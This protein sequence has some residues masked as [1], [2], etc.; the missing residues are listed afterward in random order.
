MA[1]TLNVPIRFVYVFYFKWFCLIFY[2]FV[3]G[4]FFFLGGGVVCDFKWGK[5]ER[6]IVDLFVFN[7]LFSFV[8]FLFLE[9]LVF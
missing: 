5:F 4:F 2:G 7:C 6:K 1:L 8:L 3:L 9:Y